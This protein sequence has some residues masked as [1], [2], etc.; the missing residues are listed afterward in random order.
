VASAL[1]FWPGG[2]VVSNEKAAALVRGQLG[3][4]TRG[5]LLLFRTYNSTISQN[6][7]SAESPSGA[8][9]IKTQSP[10]TGERFSARLFVRLK[11]YYKNRYITGG[12]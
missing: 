4:L 3:L 6:Q 5:G 11:I 10:K 2:L 8:K 1:S 12:I 9:F 7:I